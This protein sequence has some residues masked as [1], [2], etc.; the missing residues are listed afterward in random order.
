MLYIIS[1]EG[2]TKI[3][4]VY[5]INYYNKHYEYKVTKVMDRMEGE[6]Q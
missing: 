5:E 1:S 2:E 6:Y 4:F 3:Y